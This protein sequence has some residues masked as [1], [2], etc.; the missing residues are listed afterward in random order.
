MQDDAAVITTLVF[1]SAILMAIYVGKHYIR[2]RV[3]K[4]CNEKITNSSDS[5]FGEGYRA[6]LTEIKASLL[7]RKINWKEIIQ[8]EGEI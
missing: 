2:K 4:L 6:A 7:Q 5:T 1:L 3:T 8:T